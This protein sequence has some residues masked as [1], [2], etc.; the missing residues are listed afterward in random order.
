MLN[1]YIY[2]EIKQM[3]EES[4]YDTT[5]QVSGSTLT[6]SI[7]ESEQSLGSKQQNHQEKAKN[8]GSRFD[9]SRFESKRHS[10]K[11]PSLK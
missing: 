3:Q 10:Q 7:N 9:T 11:S 4:E 2:E 1:D 5:S 8:N 6:K